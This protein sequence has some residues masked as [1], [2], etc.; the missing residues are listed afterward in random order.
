MAEVKQATAAGRDVLVVA[1]AGTEKVPELIVASTEAPGRP[2]ALETPHTSY[3]AFNGPVVLLQPIVP[4][5][6][7]RCTTRRPSVERI[8]R[9]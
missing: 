4:E 1:G 5:A 8:A 7:V 6:L 3:A 9:G 2:N